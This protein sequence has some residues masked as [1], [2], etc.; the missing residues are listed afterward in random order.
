MG[1]RRCPGVRPTWRPVASGARGPA[2]VGH[3]RLS[4]IPGRPPSRE[5]GAA[6]S[7]P[8]RGRVATVSQGRPRTGPGCPT[9]RSRRT[10][11]VARGQPAGNWR[12]VP[13]PP[14]A[15]RPGVVLVAGTSRVSERSRRVCGAR[16]LRPLVGP[17]PTA[18]ERATPR[19]AGERAYC[20]GRGIVVGSGGGQRY[21]MVRGRAG[22]SVGDVGG[23]HQRRLHRARRRQPPC[24]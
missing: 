15:W 12:R 22:P 13:S 9:A 1:T 18:A 7:G 16:T 4:P 20:E 2:S 23:G 14:G 5:P 11:H 8:V 6:P 19:A 3:L 17:V 10:G 21:S 24:V